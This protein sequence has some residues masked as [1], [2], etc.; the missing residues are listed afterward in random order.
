M[1][2]W[3]IGIVLLIGA[4]ILVYS[5]GR[6]NDDEGTEGS[7]CFIGGV[8]FIAGWLMVSIGMQNDTYKRC[9]DGSNRYVKEYRYKAMPDG[10]MVIIDSVYVRVE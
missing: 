6:N 5:A 9:L 8:L 1:A 4:L 7:L 2:L 3:I 10:E